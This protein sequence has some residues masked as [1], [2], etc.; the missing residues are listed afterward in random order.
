MP[1]QKKCNHCGQW[2]VWDH[3]LTDRCQHCNELLQPQLAQ[4]KEEWKARIVNE[5]KDDFFTP[6]DTDGPFML[7][8]RRVAFFFHLIFGAIAWIFIWSFASTPG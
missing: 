3:K 6:K 4:E 1:S 8:T 7:A 2:T 5:K